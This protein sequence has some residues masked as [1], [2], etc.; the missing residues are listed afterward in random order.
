MKII[1]DNG[2]DLAPEILDK[3]DVEIVA[4]TITLDNKHYRGVWM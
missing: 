1:T 4:L 2:M 3:L